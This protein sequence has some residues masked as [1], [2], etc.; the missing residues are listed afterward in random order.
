M[1]AFVSVEFRCIYIKF[2]KIYNFIVKIRAR[3]RRSVENEKK[4][5]KSNMFHV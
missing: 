1:S 3:E 2:W 4:T 5:T